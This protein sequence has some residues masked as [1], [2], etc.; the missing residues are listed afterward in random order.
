[1]LKIIFISILAF[2]VV[3][4]D[5]A[6]QT[7]QKERDKNAREINKNMTMPNTNGTIGKSKY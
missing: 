4:C 5:S 3:G 7:A 2:F 6:E 1:M